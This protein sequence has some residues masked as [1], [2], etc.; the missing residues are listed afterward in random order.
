[1]SPIVGYTRFRRHQL[2]LQTVLNTGVAATRRLGVRGVPDINPNWTDQDEVDTGS[3]DTVLAP[4]RVGSD[5]TLPLAFN[6][7]NFNDIPLIMSAGVIGGQTAAA[8]GGGGY[9]WTHAADSLAATTL[10]YFTDEFADDANNLDSGPPEDGIQLI[11][12]VIQRIELTMP[13]GLGPW[14]ASTSWRFS[15]VNAHVTPTA[16][17]LL[18][19]NSVIAF[20]AD[21]ALFIDDT[22]GGIGG[23]Q[24]TDSLHSASIVIENTL[25]LKRFANGSNT[26]FQID[27][28]GLAARA[29]TA[30]F[31]FAKTSAIVAALNSETVDWLSADAVNRYVSLV[32]TST[33]LAEAGNPYSWNQRFSGT[34]RTRAE[35][36][37]GGNS[38]VELSMMGRYDLG[39]GYPYRSV[40]VNT[41]ATKP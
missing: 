4:Y 39:L 40:A 18:S 35:Q 41:L 21:T 12:G 29:I 1:M 3:I 32:T 34:W 14:Q 27:G 6:P 31:R 16:G 17:L 5:L 8:I 33:A 24:I 36:E 19:S 30:T 10:D 2:G 22:S 25:D 15:K 38:V 37:I 7:L 13:E 28:Y 11:G 20:G 26:R 23:T 9:T